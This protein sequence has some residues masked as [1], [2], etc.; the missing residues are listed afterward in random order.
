M[1]PVNN[2]DTAW[3]VVADWNQE[4]G[5]H[6][7]ELIEDIIDPDVDAWCNEY[8][9]LGVGYSLYQVLNATVGSGEFHRGTATPHDYGYAV[10]EPFYG[11]YIGGN[12]YASH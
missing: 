10:G 11:K 6:Y 4:N 12:Y 2:S 8:L 5:K 1:L 7:K 3:L 9:Y